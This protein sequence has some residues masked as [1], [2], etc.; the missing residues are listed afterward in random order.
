MLAGVLVVAMLVVGV[1]Q[2]HGVWW[3]K[4]LRDTRAEQQQEVLAAA[5]SCTVSILSYDYRRLPEAQKAASACV[6]PEFK[7]QYDQ[8]FKIVQQLAPEKHA[9]LQLTVEN[10]GVQSVSKDGKQWVI[11]LYGQQAYSDNT[12]PK[13]TPQRLDISSSVVTLT[14]ASGH[15]LVSNL[16]PTG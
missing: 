3:G 2:S 14:N 12:L 11:L 10:G 1:W 9:T 6:T 15:W 5:K 4:R 16:S 7:S 8:S 13:D